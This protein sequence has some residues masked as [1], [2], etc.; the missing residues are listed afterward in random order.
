MHCVWYC[1]SEVD[2]DIQF[3]RIFASESKVIEFHSKRPFVFWRLE[4]YTLG[5]YIIVNW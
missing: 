1:D 2:K 5:P 4:P 3:S